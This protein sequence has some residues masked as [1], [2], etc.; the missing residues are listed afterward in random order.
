M[1][2]LGAQDPRNVG[3]DPLP[4]RD[5]HGVQADVQ[6]PATGPVERRMTVGIPQRVGN[7]AGD[8]GRACPQGISQGR[9]GVVGI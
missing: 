4:G 9:V 6:Q 8:A 1:G 7:A 2:V 3:S 5:H